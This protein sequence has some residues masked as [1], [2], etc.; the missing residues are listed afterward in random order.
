VLRSGTGGLSASEAARRLAEFGP[1]DVERVERPSQALAFLAEFTHLFAVI[2]WVAA[3]LAF[4][5]AIAQPG[6]GMGTLAAAIVGVIAVNGVFS[7]WQQH[8]AE[9]ALEA[10]ERLLP[11]RVL[12]LRGGEPIPVDARALVPGDV[13]FLEAGS[14]IPTDCRV[15]ESFGLRVDNATITGESVPVALDA[16]AATEADSRRATNVALAGTL[17]VAGHGRAVVFATGSATEFSRIAGLAQ[18]IRPGLSPLQREIARVTQLV[19][20]LAAGLGIAFFALGQAIGLPLWSNVLF[21]IGIIVAN[22]PEGL[23]PT[24]TLSLAM[25]AQRMARRNALVRHLPSVEALGAATVIC[26]DKTGTLTLNRMAVRELYLGGASH[27]ARDAVRLAGLAGVHRAFF[28][29]CLLCENLHARGDGEAHEWLG[30]P[31]EVALVEMAGPALPEARSGPRIDEIPFDSDRRRLSTVHRL[32]GGLVLHSK[33][34]L[35]SLLPLCDAIEEAGGLAP[36]DETRRRRFLEVEEALGERGLR[37]LA[38]AWRPV[39]EG[40]ARETLERGLVLAGLVALED[41]PRPEVPH[42][43]ARCRAAGIRIIMVTGDHPRT[44]A[45]IARRVGLIAGETSHVVTGDVLRRMT[46]AQLQL[47]L[48][49][50]EIHFARLDADQ[51]TRI[52]ATLQRKGEVVAMTGDG[53]ND[54]PA[55]RL[56]DIGVSMGIAGTD[57]ARAASD[58]V[59]ADDNFATIVNA[60]EEGRVVFANARKFLTYILTSN[61][62]EIVPYLAF[63]LLR[64]PLPLTIVQILAVDLGTDLLPALALGAERA[65]PDVMTC[66]PR[67]RDERLITRS[68]LLR[69]YVFLGLIEAA[70]AMAAYFFVLHAGGWTWGQALDAGDPLYRRATTACLAAIVAMQVVNVLI[71][72]SERESVAQTRFAGS[73]LLAW[74]IAV[75]L[76]LIVLA[77]YTPAG[78]ALLG[79]EPLGAEVWLLFIPLAAAMLVLEEAR[80]LAARRLAAQRG[81]GAE[82]RRINRVSS[83]ADRPAP[84][85]RP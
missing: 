20:V 75:E 60:V 21:G 54:A 67:G 30:D 48:D 19:A 4:L 33:G 38:V 56:A 58:L 8:R 71:C 9:R 76:V 11:A 68:L 32:P 49:E 18:A 62:P 25:A 29:A 79:T 1:N 13:V 28:E 83:G 59:L 61:V 34:A 77:V 72:R 2:L 42:A 37:V 80:K 26:T 14:R 51:K 65:D 15:V 73:R 57:A 55:L 17:V 70:A 27:D 50:P 47:A 69:A 66:P 12:A 24:I 53:V 16:R 43:V 23:L 84:S 63:V 7:F 36:L 81:G 6:A 78:N 74:G 41:P 10:L 39:A 45:A 40:E 64:I 52:V 85:A 46:D 22:V 35:E 3:G 5:A 44:A 31:T 82:G